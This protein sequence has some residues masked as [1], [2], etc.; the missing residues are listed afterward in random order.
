MSLAC[1][2][3]ESGASAPL[4]GDVSLS[5]EASHVPLMGWQSASELWDIFIARGS[6]VLDTRGKSIG[7]AKSSWSGSQRRQGIAPT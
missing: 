7:L 1:A 6:F 4:C 3:I 2:L 5:W